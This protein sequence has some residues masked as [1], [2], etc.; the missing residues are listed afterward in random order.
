MGRESTHGYHFYSAYLDCPRK[1]FLKYGLRLLPETV[2]PALT[3]GKAIHIAMETL[4]LTDSVDAAMKDFSGYLTSRRDDYKKLADYEEDADRGPKLV[5]DYGE[6]IYP[7]ETYELVEMEKTFEIAVGPDPPGYVLTVR[8]DKILRNHLGEL[9]IGD[10]KTT[11]WSI[12]KAIKSF[13]MN[14]QLTGYVF[15]VSKVYSQERVIG[16]FV[17]VL[18]SRK[19]KIVAERSDVI[20][21]TNRDL[22]VFG[23]NIHSVITEVSN[24]MSAYESGE[25]PPEY[26][27]PRHGAFCGAFSCEYED[28]CRSNL[29]PNYIPPGYILDDWE[30]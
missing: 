14:D 30:D 22:L 5:K 20:Y 7:T 8:P 28:I 2:K 17:D 19:S 25:F 13:D 29:K 27:F 26:L 16:G 3:F 9:I 21:R 15:G 24:K 4:Y 12:G 11:K 1:W 10:Y 23:Q 6:K 18:Y